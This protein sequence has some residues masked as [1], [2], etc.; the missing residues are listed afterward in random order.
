ML[1]FVLEYWIEILFGLIISLFGY[2]FKQLLKYKKKLDATNEGI[3]VILKMSLVEKYN[4]CIKKQSITIKEKESINELFNVYKKF[5]CCDVIE[6]LMK[7]VD[8][9]PIE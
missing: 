7:K 8:S 1:N 4:L 9:I 5:E 6:D 2:L 3:V